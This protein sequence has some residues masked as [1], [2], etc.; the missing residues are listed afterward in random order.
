MIVLL[1]NSDKIFVF[2][3]TIIL[4]KGMDRSWDI[5]IL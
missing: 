3:K 1:M 2:Y 4:K 5:R